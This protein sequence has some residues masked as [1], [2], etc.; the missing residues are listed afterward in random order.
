MNSLTAGVHQSQRAGSRSCCP[1]DNISISSIDRTDKK[2]QE[3][4][5]NCKKLRETAEAKAE[6]LDD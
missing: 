1:Q 5:R 4:A 6:H 3:T 2:L